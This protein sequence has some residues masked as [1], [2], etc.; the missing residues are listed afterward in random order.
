[1]LNIDMIRGLLKQLL[2]NTV[3][4][5]EDSPVILLGHTGAGKSSLGNYLM[6]YHMTIGEGGEAVPTEKKVPMAMGNSA[7]SITVIPQVHRGIDRLLYC[8]CPGFDDN[9][10]E[11]M[12]ACTSVAM[13][14]VVSRSKNIAGAII[15]IDYNSLIT[16]RGAGIIELAR[17]LGQL[18]GSAPEISKSLVFVFNKVPSSVK[19]EY[20]IKKLK[21]FAQGQ[22]ETIV[23]LARKLQDTSAIISNRDTLET[24]FTDANLS[25]QMLHQILLDESRIHIAD[26]F[27]KGQSRIA[28]MKSVGSLSPLTKDQFNFQSASGIRAKLEEVLNILLLESDQLSSAI[29]K[30]PQ[31]ISDLQNEEAVL[32]AEVK[33]ETDFLGKFYHQEFDRTQLTVIKGEHE[34]ALREVSKLLDKFVAERNRMVSSKSDNE[35]IVTSLDTEEPCIFWS[36][37]RSGSASSLTYTS[38]LIKA[39]AHLLG[40]EGMESMIANVAAGIASHAAHGNAEPVFFSYQGPPISQ[41]DKSGSGG[42]FTQESINQKAG[43]LSLTFYGLKEQ[44][45]NASVRVFVEKRLIP[46]NAQA[47]ASSKRNITELAA[48]IAEHTRNIELL[49]EEKRSLEQTITHLSNQQS[50]K[51]ETNL[52]EIIKKHIDQLN[53]QITTHQGKRLEKEKELGE[54]QEKLSKNQSLYNIVRELIHLLAHSR[55]EILANTPAPIAAEAPIPIVANVNTGGDDG[56]AGLRGEMQSLREEIAAMREIIQSLQQQVSLLQKGQPPAYQFGPG[57]N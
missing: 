9:R 29:Q 26:I 27:D 5:A 43:R 2:V 3:V 47:I 21:E 23:S 37:S 11:E 42:S 17:L 22:E 39:G 57:P 45:W 15:V 44:S 50:Q 46:K 51:Q 18:F 7:A 24:Q 8:D 12:Q 14:M 35:S 53:S 54:V 33:R 31:I 41:Y 55:G 30:L 56:M 48:R 40:L 6:G 49:T 1:M 38:P 36:D 34:R 52:P 16:T 10:S 25:L 28:I 20:V 32:S 19:K 4:T 13:E